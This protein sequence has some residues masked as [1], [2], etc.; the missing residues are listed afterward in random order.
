MLFLYLNKN[1][2]NACKTS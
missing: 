2:H 1:D